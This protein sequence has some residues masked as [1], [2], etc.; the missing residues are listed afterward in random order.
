MTVMRTTMAEIRERLGRGQSQADS[1]A[2][3][4]RVPSSPASAEYVATLA[5]ILH[6]IH[7]HSWLAHGSEIIQS[8]KPPMKTDKSGVAGGGLAVLW[9]CFHLTETNPDVG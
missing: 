2:P 4:I 3:S 7:L 6:D 8:R 5:D 9:W 1:H